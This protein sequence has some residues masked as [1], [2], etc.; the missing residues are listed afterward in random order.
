MNGGRHE[1]WACEW[2]TSDAV[3]VR[4]VGGAAVVPPSAVGLEAQVEDPPVPVPVHEG[5]QAVVDGQ[6]VQHRRLERAQRSL[7]GTQRTEQEV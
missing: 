4:E 7:H 3:V 5:V 6:R 2:T 1:E